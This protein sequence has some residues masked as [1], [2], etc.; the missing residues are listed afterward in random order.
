M[1]P[2]EIAA[3]V[4]KLVDARDLKSLG[5]LTVP[6]QVRSRAP[7]TIGYK[8]ATWP[9]GKAEACKAFIPSSS[10]GVASKQC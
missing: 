7:C 10:L 9:S 1:H 6:V 3:R 4:A 2:I 8:L 5:H